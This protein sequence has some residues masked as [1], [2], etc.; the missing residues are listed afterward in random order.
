[1]LEGDALLAP[2]RLGDYEP[3][4]LAPERMKR[5]RDPNLRRIS[6]IACN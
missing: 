4:G 5:M 6:G 1:V 2:E 3:E